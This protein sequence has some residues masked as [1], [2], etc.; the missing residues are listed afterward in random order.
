MTTITTYPNSPYYDDFDS[1]KHFY[2]ILFKPGYAVQA[3]ELTQLQTMLQQQVADFGTNIFKEGSLVVP[4]SFMYD[5]LY[6]YVKLDSSYTTTADLGV[7]VGETITG[8]AT[9]MEAKVVNY[10]N[11]TD[12][13]PP[14]LY[15]KYMNSGTDNS[16]YNFSDDEVIQCANVTITAKTANA[17]ATGYLSL[18]HI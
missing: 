14:T 9:G 7:L 5:D 3:R 10:A 15:V 1:G 4:G 18:I 6:R 12:T 13:D 11:E 2:R 17:S 8:D 16:T